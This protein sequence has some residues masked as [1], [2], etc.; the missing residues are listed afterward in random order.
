MLTVDK[1]MDEIHNKTYMLMYVSNLET[2]KS[3]KEIESDICVKTAL[4]GITT[5]GINNILWTL[6]IGGNYIIV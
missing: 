3:K 4:I 1:D 5:R 2:I 6:V